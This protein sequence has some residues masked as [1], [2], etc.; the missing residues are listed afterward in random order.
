LKRLVLLLIDQAMGIPSAHLHMP[1]CCWCCC[2]IGLQPIVWS[3][4]RLQML[5]ACEQ[6]GEE[7]AGP[8]VPPLSSSACLFMN[9]S[10]ASS[11]SLTAGP[12]PSSTA[13]LQP[14]CQGD[15]RSC[16]YCINS[17][18]HKQKPPTYLL[19]WNRCLSLGEG[20]TGALTPAVLPDLKFAAVFCICCNILP[21]FW[22]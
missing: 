10:T 22:L 1:C 8:N 6:S 15:Q 17:D 12:V 11:K 9:A 4:C 7:S 13:R 14:L 20:S 18:L 16:P 3:T 5:L 19:V 2:C 21:D